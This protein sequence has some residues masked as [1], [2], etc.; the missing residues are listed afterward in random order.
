MN[1]DVELYAGVGYDGNAVP[2]KTIDPSLYDTE[3]VTASLGGRFELLEDSLA[4]AAT[5]TQ[6]FYF[7]RTVAARED[8][9]SES[10]LPS[11][12]DPELRSP[13]A[14]GTYNQAVGVFNL[15]VQYTF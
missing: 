5:Y 8:G 10:V 3:K 7:E 6:V 2:D 15:N 14:A 9:A 11:G 4:L 12:V 1:Q 13:D